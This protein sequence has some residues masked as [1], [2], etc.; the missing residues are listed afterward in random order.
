MMRDDKYTTILS[1]WV[2][3]EE[4]SAHTP[5]LIGIVLPFPLAM[6]RIAVGFILK[7]G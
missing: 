4:I 1:A 5:T 2:K 6:L 7:G 3:S